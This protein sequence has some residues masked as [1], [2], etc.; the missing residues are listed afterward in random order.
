MGVLSGKQENYMI[1]PNPSIKIV[2]IKGL[3]K[4]A[5]NKIFDIYGKI[6]LSGKAYKS[7]NI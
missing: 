2:N 7:I 6:V 4:E 1:Y 5:S 3:D